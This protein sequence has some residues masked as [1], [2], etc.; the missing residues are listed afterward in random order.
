DWSSDVCSSDLEV[1]GDVEQV[2]RRLVVFAVD[3]GLHHGDHVGDRVRVVDV[4]RGRVQQGGHGMAREGVDAAAGSPHGLE[5]RRIVDGAPSA[6]T[7]LDHAGEGVTEEVLGRVVD[8]RVEVMLLA[9]VAGGAALGAA[10]VGLDGEA[11]G[12]E[13]DGVAV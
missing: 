1:V 7:D 3:G 13:V 11:D 12:V 6:G 10:V 2:L 4:G 9:P 5:E 8:P